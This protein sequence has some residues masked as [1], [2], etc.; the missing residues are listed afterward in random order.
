[1]NIP[2]ELKYTADHEWVR[3][4]GDLAYVGVTDYAQREY[5]NIVCVD[6]DTIDKTLEK[7]DILGSI[8]ADKTVSDLFMPIKG[9]VTELNN[10]LEENPEQVNKDPYGKGWIIKIIPTDITEWD[11]L[12]SAKEYRDLIK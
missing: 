6:I 10:I 11:T 8:E 4:E 5:G 1:M 2:E 12:L 3:L 9:K 7:D